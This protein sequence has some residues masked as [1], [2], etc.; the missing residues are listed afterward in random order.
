[1]LEVSL[2][3]NWEIIQELRGNEDMCQALME[4]MEPEISKIRE[5][6]AREF[7]KIREADAREFEKIR[8]GEARK[9]ISCAVESFREMGIGDD[10]IREA[11]MK[12]YRLTEKEAAEYLG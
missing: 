7:E 11:I 9:L 8:E 3:A 2:R 4:I 1:M 5:A 12:N 6:D 10:R